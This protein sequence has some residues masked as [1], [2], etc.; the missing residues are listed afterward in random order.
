MKI[1]TKEWQWI[2]RPTPHITYTKSGTFVI[3]AYW[4]GNMIGPADSW[5]IIYL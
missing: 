2:E 1:I 3:V 5:L 4:R